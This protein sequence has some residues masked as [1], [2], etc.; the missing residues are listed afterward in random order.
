V[1][2]RWDKQWRQKIQEQSQNVLHPSVFCCPV[3]W[4][5]ESHQNTVC[6]SLQ[7]KQDQLTSIWY[8]AVSNGDSSPY[9]EWEC[10]IVVTGK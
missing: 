9:V 1:W 5:S 7:Q 10:S 8:Y 4:L 3:N 6:I 2:D